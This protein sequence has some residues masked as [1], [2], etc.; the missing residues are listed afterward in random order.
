MPN[1]SCW[2]ADQNIMNI[3]RI[4]EDVKEEILIASYENCLSSLENLTQ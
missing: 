2:F 3:A 4:N 1:L